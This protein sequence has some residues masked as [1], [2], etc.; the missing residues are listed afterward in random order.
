MIIRTLY[1][2]SEAAKK[3]DINRSTLTSWIK[4]QIVP[5][6]M[7][8]NRVNG[9]V[10]GQDINK[11]LKLMNQREEELREYKEKQLKR[12]VKLHNV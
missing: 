4:K 12:K 6:Y 9:F 11:L 1:T 2:K 7:T 3:L 5:I 10:S 8:P